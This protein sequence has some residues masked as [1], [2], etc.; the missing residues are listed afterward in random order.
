MKILLTGGHVTP[1]IAVIEELKKKK[2]IE[3]IFVGR[4]YAISSDRQP[5]FEYE[6]IQK[7]NIRFIELKSGRLT[8]IL[9][10]RSIIDTLKIIPGFI[11][12]LT[13]VKK[14]K[15]DAILS[16][17]GYLALPISLAG[18]VFKIP[19]FTHEQ[20]LIPGFTT[21]LIS[22]WAKMIFVSA[23]ETKKLFRSDKT[24]VS[25]NPLRKSI[26]KTYK[27]FFTVSGKRPVIYI[28]GG[29]L[30]SHSINLHIEK[31]LGLLL[32]HF[33]VIHQCGGASEY[34]DFDKFDAIKNENY[35]VRPHFYEEEIGYIYKRAD[36][37][38]SRSGANTFFE[39]IA[40]SKPAILIPL[41]WA[42]GG[43]QLK[44]AKLLA[45]AGVA[46]IFNQDQESMEL[47]NLIRKVIKNREVY[48]K[49][50]NNLK[51]YVHEHAA[52]TIVFEILKKI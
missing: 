29:S 8:R 34:R 52:A 43:E 47:Y 22:G 10:L 12:S 36:L 7:L 49:N 51:N 28:S 30:G 20:A 44:Q 14:E 27:K 31:I 50:F 18:R 26:F 38:V 15:P 39:L 32:S 13:I 17:G 9:D 3:I 11:R 24:I 33:T 19:V 6:S 42:A 40:L 21:K 5:S 1:A 46:E 45:R 41:P 48:K 16:F 2:N 23:S 37:V 4:K 35:I 25:G